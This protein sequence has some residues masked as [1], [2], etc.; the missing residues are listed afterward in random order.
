MI[1]SALMTVMTAAAIKTGRALKRDFGEIENL[2]TRL[3]AI[4]YGFK[5]TP[6]LPLGLWSTLVQEFCG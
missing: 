1:R 4:D 2:Q 3:A 6:L 5:Q